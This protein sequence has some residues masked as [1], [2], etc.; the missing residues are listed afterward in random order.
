MVDGQ[1]LPVDMYLQLPSLPSLEPGGPP[2]AQY[3][4]KRNTSRNEQWHTVSNEAISGPKAGPT[5]ISSVISQKALMWNQKNHIK[6]GL[7]ADHP[8][9]HD[10]AML[11]EIDQLQLHLGLNRDYAEVPNPNGLSAQLAKHSPKCLLMLS[12]S[13]PSFWVPWSRS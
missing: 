4:S 10:P 9:K 12:G 11:L 8:A 2:A 1:C 5:M 3:S 6:R 13:L 7:M